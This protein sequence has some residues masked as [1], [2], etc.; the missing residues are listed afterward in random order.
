MKTAHMAKW[1]SGGLYMI[2]REIIGALQEL[3]DEIG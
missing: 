1:W 3:K 2:K